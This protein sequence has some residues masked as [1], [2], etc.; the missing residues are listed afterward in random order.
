MQKNILILVLRRTRLVQLLCL[1]VFLFACSDETPDEEA[2]KS[3]VD[4]LNPDYT[5]VDVYYGTDRKIN[6]ASKSIKDIYIGDRGQFSYG[7]CQVSIPKGHKTGELEAPSLLR[8]EFSEDP[9][10]HVVLLDVQQ[11]DADS[12]FEE[13]SEVINASDGKQAFIFIHGYNVSFEAAARRT[14][15]MAYDLQFNGAPIFYSW[16]SAGTLAGYPQDEGNIEWTVPNLRNFLK[17]VIEKTQ[18]E[19][20][21][22]VAHSM[23][24]RA[25]TRVLTEASEYLNSNQLSVIKNIILTAPD[26]D[27]EIFKRDIVPKINAYN[28]DITLYV[29]SKDKALEASKKIKGYNRAGDAEDGIVLIEGVETIDASDVSTGFLAHSYFSEEESVLDDIR[30][31]MTEGLTARSRSGLEKV[32]DKSSGM[33]YWRINIPEK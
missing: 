19:S 27:A 17:D 20:I 16:P 18:A 29:S 9:A 1:S 8:F 13:L 32:V 26:V 24:N 2:S 25:L 3:G 10:L 31:L 7:V 21:H 23:G 12:Y 6:D 28:S 33:P 11:K 14:A 30:Q 15:Q 4:I 22:L 5:L